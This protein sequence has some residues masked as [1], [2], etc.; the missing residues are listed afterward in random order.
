MNPMK[1]DG[2]EGKGREVEGREMG[3]EGRGRG[4]W[5]ERKV[6]GRLEEAWK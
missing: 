6:E 4:R 3:G 2:G 1:A 5:G